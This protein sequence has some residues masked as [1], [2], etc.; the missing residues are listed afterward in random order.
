[1]EITPLQPHRPAADLPIEQ[2]A[3]NRQLTEQQKTAEAARQFE[4]LL[5]RQILADTQKPVIQSKFTDN[6]TAGGIYRDMVSNQLA[7]SISKSG[8]FGLA[9]MFEQQLGSH[10]PPSAPPASH[11]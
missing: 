6:S 1:M 8:S 3:T 10:R 4:A 7:D 2:L 11:P 9:K 5:L